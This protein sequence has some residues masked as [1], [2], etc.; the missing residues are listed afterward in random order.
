MDFNP[1]LVST[2]R[3]GIGMAH[4]SYSSP[5]MGMESSGYVSPHMAGGGQFNRQQPN[6]TTPSTQTNQGELPLFSSRHDA[7]YLIVGRVLYQFWNRT[8]VNTGEL[9]GSPIV[10]FFNL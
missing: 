1:N 4:S 10:R 5:S 8:L 9:E 3:Q 7:I 2:P 6:Y